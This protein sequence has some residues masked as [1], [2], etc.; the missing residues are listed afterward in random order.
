MKVKR[1]PLEAEVTCN[2]I[3]GLCIAIPDMAIWD[4]AM[5]R[6]SSEFPCCIVM[7]CGERFVAFSAADIPKYDVVC[8]CGSIKHWL[9]EVRIDPRLDRRPYKFS[10]S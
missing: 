4:E 6:V 7:P 2:K 8:P 5:E 9:V 3:V 1:I 10:R